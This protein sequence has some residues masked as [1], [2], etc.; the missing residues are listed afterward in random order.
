MIKMI[1]HEYVDWSGCWY[2]FQSIIDPALASWSAASLPACY[3]MLVSRARRSYGNKG[4][5][6][7]ELLREDEGTSGQIGQVFV[8]RRNAIIL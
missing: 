8:A 5:V 1:V 7:A 4:R 6:G 2:R 3:T